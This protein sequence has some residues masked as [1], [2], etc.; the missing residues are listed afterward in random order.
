ME[1]CKRQRYYYPELGASIVTFNGNTQNITSNGNAFYNFTKSGTGTATLLDNALVGGDLNVSLGTLAIGTNNLSVTGNSTITG[2]GGTATLTIGASGG[3]GWTTTG[4]VT[5]GASGVVT[6]SGASLITVGVSW[7]V[8]AGTF[9]P[10]TSTLTFTAVGTGN[11]VK[12]GSNTY[13]NV[14]WNSATAANTWDLQDDFTQS[15][16]IT[17]TKG[18]L[19]LNGKTYTDNTTQTVTLGSGFVLNIGTGILSSSSPGSMSVVVPTGATVTI[20][21]GK[22]YSAAFIVS[23]TGSF[24]ATGAAGIYVYADFTVSDTAI[25]SAGASTIKVWGEHKHFQR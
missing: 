4:S 11:T 1:T 17:M 2:S 25:F 10:D 9:T 12:S 24:T 19:N 15:Y 20:S 14:T 21:T 16:T 23:G 3:T 6:C 22:I 8:S 13:A 5:V 18:T 7:D